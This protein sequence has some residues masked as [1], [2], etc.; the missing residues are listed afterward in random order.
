MIEHAH[1]QHEIEALPK[2]CD[3]IDRHLSEFDIEPGLIGGK[4]R[5]AQ[6]MRIGI[7]ANDPP[8]LAALHFQCVKSGIAANIEHAAPAEI[9]RQQMAKSLPFEGGVISQR[10][11][12]RRLDA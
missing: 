10:M 9:L 4:L 5:L 8:C 2:P 1:E 11:G 6:I 7:D 3:I 12:W